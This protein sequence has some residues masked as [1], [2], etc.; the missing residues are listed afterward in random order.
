M[1]S[2]SDASRML[3]IKSAADKSKPLSLS[4]WNNFIANALFEQE[5]LMK[6]NIIE[7]LLYQ[8]IL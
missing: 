3:L 6:L 5:I 7:K 2:F 4:T 1:S 8:K